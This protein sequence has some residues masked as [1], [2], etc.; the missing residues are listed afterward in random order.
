LFD[1]RV[2]TRDLESVYAAMWER[3][4]SGL[5]PETFSIPVGT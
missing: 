2:F 3:Q 5:P 1:T 4:Q